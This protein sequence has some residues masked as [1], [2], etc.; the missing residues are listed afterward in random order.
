[1][2]YFLFHSLVYKVGTQIG[3]ACICSLHVLHLTFNALQSCN[4]YGVSISPV[5]TFAACCIADGMSHLRRA[6]VQF[7]DFSLIFTF[8]EVQHCKCHVCNLSDLVLSNLS[9]RANY[10]T[11]QT[12]PQHTNRLSDIHRRKCLYIVQNNLWWRREVPTMQTMR[13]N[14]MSLLY[15]IRMKRTFTCL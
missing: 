6:H 10:T 13:N 14:T 12:K 1:M 3:V 7:E 4:K 5:L 9:E 8:V 15:K 11:K 2:A